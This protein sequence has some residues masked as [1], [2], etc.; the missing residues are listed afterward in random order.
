MFIGI[1][2]T[3]SRGSSARH[4]KQQISMSSDGFNIFSQIEF[5]LKVFRAKVV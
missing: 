4:K 1:G 5:Y 2:G 3:E